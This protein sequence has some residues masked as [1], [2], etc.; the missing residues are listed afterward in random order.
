[1]YLARI[2]RTVALARRK[3][4]VARLELFQQFAPGAEKSLK[5]L[6]EG[7]AAYRAKATVLMREPAGC[8]FWVRAPGIHGDCRFFPTPKQQKLKHIK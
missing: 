5:R 6:E 2:F 3:D 8:E 4:L 1:M 7:G